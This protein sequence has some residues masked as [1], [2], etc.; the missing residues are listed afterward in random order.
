[1]EYGWMSHALGWIIGIMTVAATLGAAGA[2]FSMG[3][4]A[5]RKD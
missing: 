2:L 3:R 4:T 5:Y 1:M